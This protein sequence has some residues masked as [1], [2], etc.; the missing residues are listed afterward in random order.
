MSDTIQRHLAEV[1][2]TIAAHDRAIPG[3]REATV[4]FLA[5]IAHRQLNERLAAVRA[6]V[7][8]PHALVIATAPRTP[9]T[10]AKQP[11]SA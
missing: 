3:T 7:I 6:K 2:D 8:G 11:G 5:L 1:G 9:A 4:F 10:I